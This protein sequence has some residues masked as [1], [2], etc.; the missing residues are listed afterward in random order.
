[1][2]T[3][4]FIT[5]LPQT[6]TTWLANLFSTGGVF[7][8]HDLTGQVESVDHLVRILRIDAMDGRVGNS[9]SGLLACF[10]VVERAFPTARWV[11][12]DRDFEEAWADLS[13]FVASGPWREDVRC[14]PALHE[15]MAA[16]WLKA[17]A[18][19]V[20]NP[21]VLVVPFASLEQDA[22]MEQIW[23][24]CVPG[25]RLDTRRVRLLQTFSVRPFQSK[26]PLRV[27]PSMAADLAAAATT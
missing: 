24:H 25:V 3:P 16:Q 1:M 14:S 19:L 12:V 21:R 20:Q 22:M 18:R 6:R 15:A 27:A 7:C 5:G 8:H 10:E 4:F 11:L 2:H 23:T 17:R 13:D 26:C 9:D